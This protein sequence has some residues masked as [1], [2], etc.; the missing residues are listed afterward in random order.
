MGYEF[1]NTEDFY[2]KLKYAINNMSEIK[3]MKKNCKKE[4]E[5]YKPKNT[6]KVLYDNIEKR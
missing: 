4:A 1:L 5:K 3:K 6:L 2:L